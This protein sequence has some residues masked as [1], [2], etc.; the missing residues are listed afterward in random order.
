[1]DTLD[2]MIFPRLLALAERAWHK[3]EWEGLTNLDGHEKVLLEDWTGFANTLGYK[4]LRRLD[5]IGIMYRVPLPGARYLTNYMQYNTLL[6][7]CLL[8][9]IFINRFMPRGLFYPYN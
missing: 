7:M 1:M 2:F 3:A 6:P 4:E 8:Y 5:D 9:L